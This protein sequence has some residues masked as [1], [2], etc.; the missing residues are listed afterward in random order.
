M[1][2]ESHN[3]PHSAQRCREGKVVSPLVYF[4][5]T[6]CAICFLRISVCKII[7]FSPRK[8][9][10]SSHLVSSLLLTSRCGTFPRTSRSQSRSS[11]DTDSNMCSICWPWVGCRKSVQII[12]IKSSLDIIIHFFDLHY[13][14]II[15][16][17]TMSAKNVALSCGRNHQVVSFI[18]SDFKDTMDNTS[19]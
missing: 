16:T 15:C 11:V 12:I 10:Q 8:K 13:F 9:W 14:L 6:N 18:T 19:Q 17:K 5:D 3:S 1:N 2:Y 7:H 4:T